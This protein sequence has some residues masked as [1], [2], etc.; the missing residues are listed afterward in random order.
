ML[1]FCSGTS[2]WVEAPLILSPGFL[3]RMPPLVE[4]WVYEREHVIA[5]Q[6][7]DTGQIYNAA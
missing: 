6:H 1:F 7:P 4:K 3:K 2:L 5:T